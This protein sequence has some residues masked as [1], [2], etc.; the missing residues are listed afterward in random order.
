MSENDIILHDY[1]NFFSILNFFAFNIGFCSR[2]MPGKYIS[3]EIKKPSV[4]AKQKGE[5]DQEITDQFHVN[6][7]TIS[8]I[9]KR[10]RE[11]KTMKHSNT[12]FCD[13]VWTVI[14]EQYLFT[15]Y[16]DRESSIASRENRGLLLYL[17]SDK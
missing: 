6:Q 3:E 16:R 8:R 5:T 12:L 11:A 14:P 4:E 13:V 9:F 10:W 17:I 2:K 1:I 15:I 7:S